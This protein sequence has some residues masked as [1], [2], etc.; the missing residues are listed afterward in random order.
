[1][2]AVN[3]AKYL[4]QKRKECVLWRKS[5]IIIIKEKQQAVLG[6]SKQTLHTK[7]RRM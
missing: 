6:I 1:M 5:L 3:Y 4:Q 2:T 7:N